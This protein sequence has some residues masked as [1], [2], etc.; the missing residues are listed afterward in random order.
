VD[1]KMQIIIA[2]GQEV[3]PTDIEGVLYTHPKV[4]EAE[5]VGDPDELRGESLKAGSI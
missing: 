1:R 3:Y 4:V 5:A 2:V